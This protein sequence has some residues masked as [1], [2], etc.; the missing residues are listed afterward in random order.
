[1]NVRVIGA[2]DEVLEEGRDVL[3][4]KREV[5][6]ARSSEAIRTPDSENSFRHW[7][8]GDLPESIEVQRNRLRFQVYPAIEDHGSYVSRIEARSAAD[9]AFIS[10]A[11]ITRLVLLT[12]PQQA[13]YISQRIAQNRELVLLSSGLELSQPL[14]QG[15]TWRAFRETF[16]PDDVPLPRTE[17]EFTALLEAH[18]ADLNDV[19]ERLFDLLLQILKEWRAVRMALN[20]LHS[21]AFAAAV[22]DIESHLAMLF[23]ADFIQTTAQQWLM[24]YP[25]YLKALRRRIARLTDNVARDAQLAAQIAPFAESLRALIGQQVRVRPRP[26]LQQFRWMLQEFRVSLFAQELKA[27]LRVSEKRLAEQLARAQ[28]EARQ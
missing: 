26:E 10:R 14:P 19:S 3:A 28:A 5:R 4:I 8:F 12:L 6:D 2:D 11:G 18:R 9:A 13:R 23:P 1:M 7:A 15:L 17:A 25:R 22:A 24:Q 16:L 21:P 27:I 20:G